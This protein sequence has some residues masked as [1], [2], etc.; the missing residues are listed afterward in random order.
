MAMKKNHSRDAFVGL[1]LA[2]LIASILW[3]LMVLAF[4]TLIDDI[5]S[6]LS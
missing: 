4:S 2:I 3:Y 6:A 1:V 5:L